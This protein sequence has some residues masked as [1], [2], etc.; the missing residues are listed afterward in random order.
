M[1]SDVEALTEIET[2][3]E[4]EIQMS[5]RVIFKIEE[6]RGFKNCIEK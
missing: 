1:T 4:L 6:K 2:E 5:L 3:L